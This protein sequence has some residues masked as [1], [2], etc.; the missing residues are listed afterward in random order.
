MPQQN[1]SDAE[2]RAL[3]VSA[4]TIAIVGAS[5]KP[6]RPSHG[7]MKKLL[8]AGYRVIPVNPNEREV[9]GQRAYPSLLDVPE[10]IDVVDVFRRPEHTEA[11]AG[12]ALAIGAKAFWL[13]S[14]IVNEAAAAKARAG[15]LV[16]VMDECIGVQHALLG[17]P[18][19]EIAP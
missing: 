8:S 3:L 6:E 14:G 2:V 7:I 11:L 18:R 9:L 16:V 10:R 12:E 19:K 5:S 15:G 1:P 13:Q 17:V 4:S